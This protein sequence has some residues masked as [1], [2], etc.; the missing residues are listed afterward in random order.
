MATVEPRPRHAR[1]T[2]ELSRVRAA[3]AELERLFV[4]HGER[5]QAICAAILGNRHEAEDAAQQVFVAAL[6][7]LRGGTVPR[8]AGAWLAT[9]ARH[10]SWARA[11]YRSPVALHEELPDVRQEDPAAAVVRRAELAE[12]WRAIAELPPAQRE[13]LLLREMRGLGYEELA[14]S[15]RLSRGSVRSLLSRARHTL[16]MRIEQGAAALAGAQWLNLLTR[17]FG[18]TSNPALSS[19]T[20]TAAAGLGALAITGGAIVAP[21]LTGH[22]HAHADTGGVR[23]TADVQTAAAHA[24]LVAVTYQPFAAPGEQSNLGTHR[25][26][27]SKAGSDDRGQHGE[28]GGTSGDQRGRDDGGSAALNGEGSS[29]GGSH[30]GSSGSSDGGS[31]STGSRSDG[32]GG[33]GGGGT[34]ITS[35]SGGGS[36]GSSEGSSDSS[37]GSDSRGS[38]SGPSTIVLSETNGGD[39]VDTSSLDGSGGSGSGGGGGGEGF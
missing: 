19:A 24:G 7:A 18:E 11:R 23:S 2:L 15:M 32:D 16:R 9:I 36:G 29:G 38:T 14:E 8:D 4:E 13:A 30:D 20:R 27:H 39:N 35:G 33:H 10:E 25:R 12:A 37:A 1:P 31:G 34:R 22:P 26:H 21:T 5:V 17:L 28:S 6:H 3:Q